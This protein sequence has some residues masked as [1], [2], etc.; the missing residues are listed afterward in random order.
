MG[1][2]TRKENVASN[3]DVEKDGEANIAIW[4]EE[5]TVSRF[6]LTHTFMLFVQLAVEAYEN[7]ERKN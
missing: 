3:V 7:D 1:S 4:K 5:R 6:L 2:V